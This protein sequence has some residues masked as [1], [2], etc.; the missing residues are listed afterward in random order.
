MSKQIKI[1]DELHERL[2]HIADN[3]YR[4]IGGQIE[5]MLDELD[6]Q[7][8]PMTYRP[9]LKV[10]HTTT[11]IKQPIDSSFMNDAST[12]D[13][14]P[15]SREI[16]AAAQLEETPSPTLRRT[17]GEVLTEI[18]QQE[19]WRDDELEYCQD[20]DTRKKIE[21][22]YNIAISNLWREYREIV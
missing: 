22:E 1:S 8:T 10:D 4:T 20:L 7:P 19:K 13:D 15:R 5:C 12:F 14:A 18:K 11:M 9:Q 17:K 3:N 21:A 16:A 6:K 2:Q